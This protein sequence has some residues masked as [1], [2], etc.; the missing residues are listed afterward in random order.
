VQQWH[1]HTLI[2]IP[3]KRRLYIN[4]IGS[5]AVALRVDISKED[6]AGWMVEKTIKCAV[7]WTSFS[8]YREYPMQ[9]PN[10]MRFLRRSGI[11]SFPSTLWTLIFTA[12][13]AKSVG[14]KIG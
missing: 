12:G 13:S 9:L 7:S 8:M 4:G 6:D 2:K 14:A 3:L 1:V 10:S 11:E 5:Y